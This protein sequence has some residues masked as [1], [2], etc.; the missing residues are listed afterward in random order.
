[1]YVAVPTAQRVSNFRL[2]EF[3]FEIC[4]LKEENSNLCISLNAIRW[5]VEMVAKEKI[6]SATELPV[7]DT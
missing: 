2:I 7:A 3:T 5:D 1:M 4:N 6:C